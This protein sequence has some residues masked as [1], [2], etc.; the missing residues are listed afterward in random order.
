MGYLLC[1]EKGLIV[2]MLK[3]NEQLVVSLPF[4]VFF[5]THCRVKRFHSHICSDVMVGN[6][7]FIRKRLLEV[8]CIEV[9]HCR[10]RI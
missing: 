1:T 9:M 8:C 10:L 6:F 3:F 2:S 5:I 4:L 7:R